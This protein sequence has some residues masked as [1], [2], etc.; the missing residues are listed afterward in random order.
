VP[1]S[2]TYT[3]DRMTTTDEG[4]ESEST[5]SVIERLSGD[6]RTGRV[7]LTADSPQGTM[8]SEADVAP[9]GTRVD[10][11]VIQSPLGEIECD[12]QP[13]WLLY[14][15]FAAGSTW[16][17]ESEC[18]DTATGLQVDI[19]ISGDGAVVGSEQVE[20]R[21]RT[22]T[23]WVVETTTVTDVA[24]TSPTIN[25]RQQATSRARLLIDPALGMAVRTVTETDASGDFQQGR[26]TVTT[27]LTGIAR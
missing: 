4:T 7:R 11:T 12:W 17:F 9:A 19:T 15:A 18:S 21:G 3:Y 23:A 26:S 6:D 27:V 14:G 20:S 2:G 22:V 13:P 5:T 24:V 16:T 8:T 10:R 25:G 1:R